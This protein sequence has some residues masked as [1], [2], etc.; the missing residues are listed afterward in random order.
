M[1]KHNLQ[2]LENIKVQQI[3]MH[4]HRLELRQTL[5]SLPQWNKKSTKR[6]LFWKGGEELMRKRKFASFGIAVSVIALV[7]VTTFVYLPKNTTTAYAEQVAQKSFETVSGLTPE[8]QQVL[9]EKVHMDPS[10]L[11]REAKSAKDL[12][13]LTYDQF[14]KQYPMVK[15]SFSTN[16]PMTDDPNG[17]PDTM[18]MHNLTFLQFTDANDQKVVLG[19]DKD[20]LPV[21][22]FIQGK[23]GDTG[24]SVQGKGKGNGPMTGS[25][26][27]GDGKPGVHEKGVSV[28]HT[29][30]QGNTLV[31]NGKKYSVPEGTK[32]TDEPPTVKVEGNDV[33]I[34]GVKATPTE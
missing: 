13:T 4:H 6:F 25:V 33:Y 19:I 9:K 23:D 3:D 14:F 2:D 29:D 22:S 18:D 26:K 20:N 15:M 1:K 30:N 12:K 24:F 28:M 5:L 10:Q 8:Q 32:L 31:I 21:F 11:L 7:V 34:N 17:T 27:I 16:G